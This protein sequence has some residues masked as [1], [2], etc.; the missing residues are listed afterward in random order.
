MRVRRIVDLSVPI[1]S[2]TQTYPG[3][4]V[5][6]LSVHSTVERDGF[7]LLH[8]DMGS[9]TGTHV[10]APFHFQDSGLRVDQLDLGLFTGPGV[11]IDVRGLGPRGR[12]GLSEISRYERFLRPGVIALIC[13]GWLDF[14]GTPAYFDHPY[15]SADA[16]QR[17]LDLGV[18]TF[19]IDA[20]NIDETPSD[21]HPGVG[22]PVHHLIA[23]A[24]GVIG[25]NFRN[26]EL[27]DFPDPLVSCL[28]LAL[29]NADGAPVRAV[30]MQLEV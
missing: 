2:D 30:A 23:S 13:T 12:V 5:P 22:Y 19:C 6:R 26:L 21:D 10:D 29:E 14:Y 17:M 24:G 16:C 9:Q 15:L 25:E 3:D 4:P 7:N 28:P 1:G 11:L 20:I 18:R 8:V 27:V